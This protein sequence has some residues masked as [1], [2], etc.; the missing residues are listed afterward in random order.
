MSKNIRYTLEPP[1]LRL[2]HFNIFY[3]IRTYS[4]KLHKITGY[5]KFRDRMSCNIEINYRDYT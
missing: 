1:F 4:V 5:F 3:W 2:R